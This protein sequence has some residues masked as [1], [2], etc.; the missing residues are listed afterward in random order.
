MAE[1]ASHDG[2][3]LGYAR[4]QLSD[5]YFSHHEEPRH[6][7]GSDKNVAR[8]VRIFKSRCK[9]EEE[10]NFLKAVLDERDVSRARQSAAIVGSA[11]AAS[12]I[13]QLPILQGCRLRC[14]N[15]WARV[16]A[17]KQHLDQNDQW[18]IVRIY[19]WA[20][21]QAQV[22]PAEN[23]Q[24][25]EEY[26]NE[27]PHSDGEIFRKVCF[28]RRA[29][30]SDHERGWWERLS[31]SKAKDLRQLLAVEAY[32]KAFE[33]LLEWPG[34]WDSVHL[35]SLHRL[36]PMRCEEEVLY[37][38]EHISEVWT[39]I[40]CP[41]IGDLLPGAVDATTVHHLQGLSP[42]V[43]CADAETVRSLMRR[44]VVFSMVSDVRTRDRLLRSILDYRDL[45]PSLYTFFE[46]LK[47]LEPGAQIL[48]SLLPPKQ[49]RTIREAFFATYSRP[50]ELLVEHSADD[51]RRHDRASQE[52]EREYAYHQVWL[53]AL[54]NCTCMI[55]TIP[56]KEASKPKPKACH[57]NQLVWQRFGHLVW[58]VG[59]EL[60]AAARLKSDDVTLRP[61]ESLLSAWDLELTNQTTLNRLTD[62]LRG[63]K[64]QRLPEICPTAAPSKESIALERRVGRP[65]E[66]DHRRDRSELFLPQ[67]YNADLA[68]GEMITSFYCVRS[69]FRRC[70][71]ITATMI[72]AQISE[73][74]PPS[75]T[76]ASVPDAGCT[77]CAERFVEIE[78]EQSRRA[79]LDV[80]LTIQQT[81]ITHLQHDLKGSEAKIVRLEAAQNV[82][83]ARSDG[84]EQ[85]AKAQ[86]TVI[87]QIEDERNVARVDSQRLSQ[88]HALSR[89]TID[90]LHARQD[91][92]KQERSRLEDECKRLRMSVVAH[93][94]HI[95]TQ[96]TII[97]NA[98]QLS[99]AASQQ[100]TQE[101]QKQLELTQ[102]VLSLQ[103]RLQGEELLV[104]RLADECTQRKIELAKA[105][106]MNHRLTVEVECLHE[107]AEDTRT[108]READVESRQYAF[109]VQ[110]QNADGALRSA[111]IDHSHQ[112]EQ[113]FRALE[114]KQ[115]CLGALLAQMHQDREKYR[116][117]LSNAQQTDILVL[118][119]V[120]VTETG[121]VQT[122]DLGL[123]L[124]EANQLTQQCTSA[125]SMYELFVGSDRK[126]LHVMQGGR[127][128]ISE[129]V[130]RAWRERKILWVI[131][132]ASAA[133][134][135]ET[136]E[137]LPDLAA[138]EARGISISAC[139]LGHPGLTT[140]R[141]PHTLIEP[142]R[143][144][145]DG[146]DVP[147]TVQ[148]TSL[149]KRKRQTGG[150]GEIRSVRR[151]AS[152]EADD[153]FN[154]RADGSLPFCADKG[155]SEIADVP[156]CGDDGL[157]V[158]TAP[159]DDSL[160]EAEETL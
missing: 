103:Q 58:T 71:K 133:V 120:R 43:S 29:G 73:Q 1:D 101:S 6:R 93:E 121:E 105:L 84:L 52:Q 87:A 113:L 15:G 143:S 23:L 142:A 36:L 40:T 112:A 46:S 107:R 18:W 134:L 129:H 45:I 9:R 118:R 135:N 8:M 76:T 37:Y 150:L 74:T 34:L 144:S 54:R 25:A 110:K 80:N 104:G 152:W 106:E 28:Y 10:D 88:A 89:E 65:F 137:R 53:Y 117:L 123:T 127:S 122:A 49:K 102:T 47:Y 67:M 90:G 94:E 153:S 97:D 56:R 33:K 124:T 35:G 5:L 21:D 126:P 91:D 72:T 119:M 51:L 63:A 145:T 48:K 114:E 149:K 111:Q 154:A 3:C 116:L 98:K 151:R 24:A 7:H 79:E 42:S 59:F 141:S 92:L 17:A 27:Q 86:Q 136:D 158:Q 44:R 96:Q 85:Q 109:H 130:Y 55:G 2:N 64:W 159:D 62:I 57:I 77:Q 60:E 14:L 68:D 69:M 100:L 20:A 50:A 157:D 81:L 13:E 83:R 32:A 156:V 125:S 147:G 155:S 30:A 78:R 22:S 39:V 4:V 139:G 160:M 12:Q 75:A 82:G 70:F 41:V 11:P 132:T 148:T 140:P 38:L 66:D 138:L 128:I 16:L 95:R 19:A 26:R 131:P 115:D 99:E 108:R 146:Q 61:A 31:L